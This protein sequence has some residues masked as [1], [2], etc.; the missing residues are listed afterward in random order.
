MQA[1]PPPPHPC[2]TPRRVARML[3]LQV[4][5]RLTPRVAVTKHT[6]GGFSDGRYFLTVL[7]AMGSTNEPGGAQS[8]LQQWCGGPN[9]IRKWVWALEFQLEPEFQ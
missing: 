2:A 6:L 8:I 5:P 1:C 7:G 3:R 4:T 9:C